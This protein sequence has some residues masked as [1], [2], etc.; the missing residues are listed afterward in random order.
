MVLGAV[1]WERVSQS[2]NFP[3]EESLSASCRDLGHKHCI[4]LAVLPNFFLCK[5][6]ADSWGQLPKTPSLFPPEV[7]MN[8]WVC[9]RKINLGLPAAGFCTLF[10]SLDKRLIPLLNMLNY[11]QIKVKALETLINDKTYWL[12]AIPERD[13]AVRKQIWFQ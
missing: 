9:R 2:C 12:L 1:T 8:S 3:S 6:V 4:S 11:P 7:M 5:W 10:P 13:F